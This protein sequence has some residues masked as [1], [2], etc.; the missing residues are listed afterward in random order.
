MVTPAGGTIT[1]HCSSGCAVAL[2]FGFALGFG[3]A[4]FSFCTCSSTQAAVARTL[5]LGGGVVRLS[6]QD[7]GK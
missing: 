4:H 1:Q 5:G 3:C 6:V 2:G 7:H